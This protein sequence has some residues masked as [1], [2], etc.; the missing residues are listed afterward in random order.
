[1]EPSYF[2]HQIQKVVDFGKLHLVRKHFKANLIEKHP[3]YIL[4]RYIK[5]KNTRLLKFRNEF[6]FKLVYIQQI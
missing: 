2:I 5:Y 4:K 3:K 1:M 6:C